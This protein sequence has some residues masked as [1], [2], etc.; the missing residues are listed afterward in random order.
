MFS[1]ETIL[2]A[3]ENAETQQAVRCKGL[4][5]AANNDEIAFY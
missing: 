3:T 2:E 1:L 5:A 4:N